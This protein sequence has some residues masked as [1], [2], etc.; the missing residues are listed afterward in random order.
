MNIDSPSILKGK[1]PPRMQT[2]FC[3]EDKIAQSYTL[4][5]EKIYLV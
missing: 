5:H 4:L 2:L 3:L 1:T